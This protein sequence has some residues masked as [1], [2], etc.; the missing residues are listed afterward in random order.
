MKV[1]KPD[2]RPKPPTWRFFHKTQ[3]QDVT[4]GITSAE[5]RTD[6]LGSGWRPSRPLQTLLSR[7]TK[8][9]EDFRARPALYELFLLPFWIG[10]GL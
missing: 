2:V 8:G 9:E 7:M 1:V 10:Q 4:C 3:H 5:T 6:K